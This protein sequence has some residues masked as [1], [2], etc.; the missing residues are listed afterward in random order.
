MASI[1]EIE[2]LEC[3]LPLAVPVTL[4]AKV[5]S[6]RDMIVVGVG[7]DDGTTGCAYGYGRGLP[8]AEMARPLARGLI[9]TSLD[10]QQPDIGESFR[11][12]H[13]A[14]WPALSR[15]ASLL[16]IA[17]W[18]AWLRQ[19]SESL[20]AFLHGYPPTPVPAIPVVGYRSEDPAPALADRILAYADQGHR[21]VKVVLGGSSLDAELDR[22]TEIL[23]RAG[24]AAAIGF[25][26]HYRLKDIAVASRL[27]AQLHDH[28][29]SFIEDPISL[30]DMDGLRT[31]HSG[32]VPLA[33]GEDA[34]EPSTWRQLSDAVQMLRVD[35]TVCG[36]IQAARA[37]LPIARSSRT[38]IY[39][40]VFHRL[41]ARLFGQDADAVEFIPAE[42]GT[43][44]IARYYVNPDAIFDGSVQPTT[45]PGVGTGLDLSALRQTA[46]TMRWQEVA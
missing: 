20:S 14:V 34:I 18:D 6:E 25:D 23:A 35:A 9:G 10:E 7:L 33:A 19:R 16:D 37:V 13:A 32:S 31:I 17:V 43:E 15:A 36:G 41:H 29:A 45:E 42:E 40:H 1:R 8:L 11:R 2:I 4:G 3:H 30:W 26:L 39:P 12:Q 28:G 44:P 38:G 5:I 27:A 24:T 22:A 46:N 21:T